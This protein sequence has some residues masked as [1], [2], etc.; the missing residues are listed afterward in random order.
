M[1]FHKKTLVLKN[2]LINSRT[3]QEYEINSNYASSYEGLRSP[4]MSTGDMNENEITER[5]DQ[6]VFLNNL[7][8]LKLISDRSD[9]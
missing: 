1:M 3:A 4:V 7:H 2:T 8:Y 6:G 9:Y 5:I